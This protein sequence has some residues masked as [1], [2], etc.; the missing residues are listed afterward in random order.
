MKV[1]AEKLDAHKTVLELEIPQ[2]EV[3]KAID[4]AYQ[5]LAGKVNIPGF[6]KGKVP[7]KVLEMRLGKAALLDE[8]FDIIAPDAYI[9]ALKEQNIEPVARPELEVVKLE[10]GQPLVF[11]ATVIAKPEITIG[12]YKGLKVEKPS[13]EV[14]ATDIEKQLDN[15][16]NRHAKMVVAENAVIDKGDF[17]VIDFEGFMDGEAFKGGE[18]KG[19]P[20]EIGAGAFI[21]GFE[22]QLIGHKAGDEVDVNVTFPAEY[23]AKDLA[24]KE[25]L[26]KVKVTDVKRKEIPELDDDFV[27]EIGEFNTVEELRA[28]VA[29]NLKKDAEEKAKQKIRSSAVQAAVDNASV[30]IPEVM[31][32]EHIDNRLRDLDIRLQNSG[33]NLEKYLEFT[34]ETI[35]SIRNSYRE[36]AINSIKTEL[37]LDAVAKAEGIEVSAEDLDAEIAMMAAA[38]Q[39]P[40][41]DVK[42]III[43]EGRVETLSRSILRKK[44][45]ELIIN[46][47][48]AE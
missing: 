28:D 31:V 30:D 1:T 48:V 33:M 45:A 13:T 20:L 24:G 10:E 39:A 23:Q 44:A 14:D 12:E 43:Q 7:R 21:P 38:Y 3:A 25:A 37:L 17:A 2:P 40:V 5:R 8:A 35:E 6:R 4:K 18:G 22:D 26:F 9:E 27:K 47:V 11:K 41:E 42:R 46:A 29:N 32:E 15:L 36:S 16:R 19:Y 34:K